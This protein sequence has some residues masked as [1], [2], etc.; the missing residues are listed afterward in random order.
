LAS[1]ASIAVG[2]NVLL[3]AANA[4]GQ[5]DAPPPPAI[6]APPPAAEAPPPA[7]DTAPVATFPVEP[8][9]PAAAPA[10]PPPLKSANPKLRRLPNRSRAGAEEAAPAAGA[11]AP[12]LQ[13][14]GALPSQP[15]APGEPTPSTAGAPARDNGP[16]GDPPEYTGR[17]Q[18][19]WGVMLDVGVPDGVVASALYRPIRWARVNAGLGFNAVSPGIRIGGALVPFGTGPF[20]SVDFGHYF[21]GD[22][23]GLARTFAAD[24]EDSVLLKDVGYDYVNLRLG[25]ELGGERFVFIMKGGFT[26]L[27]TTIHHVD[28][29]LDSNAGAD[30]QT[31]VTVGEDPVLT[32]WAPSLDL[33]A[34]FFF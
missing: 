6:D 3:A 15:P 17:K 24:H 11:P 29:L 19:Q 32:A 1:S 18:H 9:A 25:L 21:G 5:A 28:E 12:A 7:A 23:N 34:A 16:L 22:A 30:G 13:Q 33:G 14:Q 2:V 31:S 27:W 10:A 20:A 4:F 8:A 26:Y